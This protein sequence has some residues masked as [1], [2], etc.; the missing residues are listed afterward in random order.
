MT[1]RQVQIKTNTHK[2]EERQTGHKII[3]SRGQA[4]SHPTS[5]GDT[6][7][8]QTLAELALPDRGAI[9]L[10]KHEKR[11]KKQ[12]LKTQIIMTAIS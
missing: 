5:W 6:V 1:D 7:N 3:H 11:D 10:C 2:P 12:R 8:R 4:A 9:G